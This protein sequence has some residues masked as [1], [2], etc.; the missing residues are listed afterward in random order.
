MIYIPTEYL[1]IPSS[2]TN[3]RSNHNQKFIQLFARTNYYQ[4]SFLPR[5][6]KDWNNLEIE[7]LVNCDIDSFKRYLY[8]SC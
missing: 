8:S 2:L 3:T 1:P 6:I 4:N 5:A 7:D